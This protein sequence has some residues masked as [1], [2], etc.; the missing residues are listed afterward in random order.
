[1]GV[2]QWTLIEPPVRLCQRHYL[3][4][5]PDQSVAQFGRRSHRIP[6]K[7][8]NLRNTVDEQGHLDSWRSKM[9]G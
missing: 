7:P 8:Y 4:L 9:L 3:P 2:E 5:H 6:V 1:M